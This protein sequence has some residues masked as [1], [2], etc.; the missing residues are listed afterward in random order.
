MTMTEKKKEI[1]TTGCVWNERKKEGEKIKGATNKIMALYF[2]FNAWTTKNSIHS[3]ILIFFSDGE[4]Y[5]RNE[6]SIF[7]FV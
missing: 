3:F 4:E 1:I 5:E 2:P 7:V 6:T